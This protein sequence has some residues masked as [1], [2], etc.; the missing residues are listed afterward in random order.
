VAALKLLPMKNM[1]KVLIGAA[2]VAGAAYAI[3]RLKGSA[4]PMPSDA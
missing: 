2:A 4:H 1:K 3:R